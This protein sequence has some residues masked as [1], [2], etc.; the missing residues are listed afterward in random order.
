MDSEQPTL[1]AVARRSRR[2]LGDPR[3]RH[4]G[5]AVS[6][7]RRHASDARR[8]ARPAARASASTPTTSSAID[9][10]VDPITPTI[11][12]Y[13]RPSSGLE[14]KFSMPFCA[15]AAIVYGRVGVETFDAA[16][17]AR[18]GDRRA[19]AARRM[20]VDPA[21]DGAAPPL[22]QARVTRHAAG[23]PR[24]RRVARTARAA[25][26]TAGER[27]RTGARSSCRARTRP[28]PAAA[29][30]GARALRDRSRSR[31]VRTLIDALRADVAE[32]V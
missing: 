2:A 16:R 24:A 6:V 4:H 22:T 7:L 5:E 14:A 32:A 19:D 12:I 13:D 26:P 1:G 18:P 30:R 28:L 15:A 31:D 29:E 21:L 10:G 8:D 3:H 25:I 20:R 11:L 17:L 23:R 27:R 9:I